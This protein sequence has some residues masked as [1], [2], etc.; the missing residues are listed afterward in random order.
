[1]SY[2]NICI[3]NKYGDRKT[4]LMLKIKLLETEL[5]FFKK[6]NNQ[7]INDLSNIPEAIE[8]YGYVTL[9]NK[10]DKVDIKLVEDIAR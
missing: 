7:L 8:E 6:I 9:Y 10:E 3:P 5:E 4:E 1:M 2:T